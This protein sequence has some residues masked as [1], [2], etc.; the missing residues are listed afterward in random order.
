MHLLASN[1][2]PFK[3][4]SSA[5]TH[6]HFTIESISSK[7]QFTLITISHRI[8]Y[9]QHSVTGRAKDVIRGYSCNPAFFDVP[10][11]ELQSD[12]GSPQH[13]VNAHI[14]R[15]ESWS[16]VTSQNPHTVV[17]FTTFLKQ[18]V[19]S[20]TDLHYTADLQSSTVLSIAKG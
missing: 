14:K 6:W 2:H 18:M 4:P 19:H 15:L 11:A 12:F 3:F 13:V 9:F 20:F 1:Y 7:S 5:V 17:S 16:R 8:T 10:L